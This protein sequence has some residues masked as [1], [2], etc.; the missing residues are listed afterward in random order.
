MKRLSNHYILCL[1]ILRTRR[2][3]IKKKA[4][5]L[6]LIKESAVVAYIYIYQINIVNKKG[7]TVENVFDHNEKR[8]NIKLFVSM[9]MGFTNLFLD[10]IVGHGRYLASSPLG[11]NLKGLLCGI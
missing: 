9:N 1:P 2:N 10:M 7:D 8:A 4:K 3:E 11:L 6:C 5:T